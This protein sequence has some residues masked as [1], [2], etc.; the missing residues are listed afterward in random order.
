[1][2]LI[3]GYTNLSI[4]IYAKGYTFSNISH[5]PKNKVGLLLGTSRYLKSGGVNPFFQYRIEAAVQLFC[6]GKIDYILVSGDNAQVS[7]NEPREF[8]RE[9]VR[10]GIPEEKIILDFAGFR[11]LDSVIR[12]KEVFGQEQITIISQHFHNERAI[13]LAQ[14]NGIDAI[15]FDAKDPLNRHNV[16]WR[17]Y[18]AKTKAYFDV[19]VN[20][21]PK[22]LGDPIKID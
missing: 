11:T 4:H 7:Y 3:V 16:Y 18:F 5:I 14:K 1:M 17:E 22:Y 2:L 13:Y 21:Q 15:G 9:L 20:K 8:R 19:L 6:K 12:S 10:Q